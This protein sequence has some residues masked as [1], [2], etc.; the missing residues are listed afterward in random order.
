MLLPG[1]PP[2]AVSRRVPL[3]RRGARAA[4]VALAL[5][6][7]TGAAAGTPAVGAVTLLTASTSDAAGRH[8]PDAPWRWPVEGGRRVIAPFRA[9]A[10]EYGP[11][12]RGMDIAAAPGAQVRA[13]ADGVVAFRGTVVDRP[14]LT[15]D[16]GD[17]YVSTWEPLDSPLTPGDVVEAGAVIGTVTSGGHS[18]RG[19][20]HVGVRVD[21]DYVNPRPL[22]GD[23][24]R[25][26]LLPCC[27]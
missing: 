20:M 13:P 8:A 27:E 9:P 3:R 22:F 1:P 5:A 7:V 19:T 18:V 17:G 11:G 10:H 14:L 6:L 2:S 23:V 12:H 21:G 24:P 16:H 25:A 4:R 15:I 26:V